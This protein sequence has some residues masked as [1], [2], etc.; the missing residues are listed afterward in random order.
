MRFAVYYSPPQRSQL[1]E[2]GSHWL[3]YNAF[4]GEILTQPGDGLLAE[5][6]RQPSHYGLH[7]TLKAPFQLKPGT[8]LRDFKASTAALAQVLSNVVI[9]RL[10]LRSIEGFLALVP[11]TQDDEL[12]TFAAAC[13]RRLDHLRAPPDEAEISKRNPGALT[14]RQREYLNTWGYPYV[15]DQFR[16]HIT[17][18]RKLS[19]AEMPEILEIA[20]EHFDDVFDQPLAISALTTFVEATPSDR[21]RVVD[22]LP[23]TANIMAAYA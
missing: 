18:T 20:R 14:A 11:E 15:F 13:V 10:V 6:T 1:H 4:N 8:S 7:A 21:F 9:H 2:L 5:V 23:L 22:E 16:F 12:A 19:D 17:L 3:G